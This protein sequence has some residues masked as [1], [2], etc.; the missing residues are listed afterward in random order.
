MKAS[1]RRPRR[2]KRLR[3]ARR[4]GKEGG[5]LPA[6]FNA[7]NEAAVEASLGKKIR[8]PDIWRLVREAMDAA[9]A[10]ARPAL[11]DILAA[12]AQAREKTSGAAG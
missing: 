1:H 12:D 9:P 6:V 8:F 4:A 7:A 3:L 11:A 5:V 2:G 10:I